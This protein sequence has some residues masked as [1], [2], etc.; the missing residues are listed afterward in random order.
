MRDVLDNWF[1]AMIL[2]AITLALAVIAVLGLRDSSRL[3]AAADQQATVGA[4]I[5]RLQTLAASERAE[6]AGAA[7]DA[8]AKSLLRKAAI[9][10]ESHFVDRKSFTEPLASLK[11]IEPTITWVASGTAT[12]ASNQVLVAT[13]ATSYTLSTIAATGTTFTYARDADARVTK[14]CSAGCPTG[15]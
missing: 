3:A 6:T 11:A 15:W 5:E 2:G 9:A 1:E 13:T 4:T 8:N 14:G 10:L 12:A 7:P